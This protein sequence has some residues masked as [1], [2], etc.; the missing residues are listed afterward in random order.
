[1]IVVPLMVDPWKV[2]PVKAAPVKFP[3]KY[4]FAVPKIFRVERLHVETFA[5]NMLA[6]VK[7]LRDPTLADVVMRLLIFALFVLMVLET[8]RFVK[9]WIRFDEFM[10]EI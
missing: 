8:T 10:F 3:P 9:G 5:E 6:P 4:P 7:T 1:M 2:P